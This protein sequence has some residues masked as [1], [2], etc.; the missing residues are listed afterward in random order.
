M[1]YNIFSIVCI[2]ELHANK[3]QVDSNLKGYYKYIILFNSSYSLL[4]GSIKLIYWLNWI[5]LLNKL[6][7]K[8]SIYKSIVILHRWEKL[9]V[10][11][12]QL[13]RNK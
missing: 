1:Q 10:F 8:L 11:H 9:F 2:S 12:L 3:R 7:K 13:N 6:T 4:F 5:E